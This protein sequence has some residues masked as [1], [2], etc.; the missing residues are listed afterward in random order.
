MNEA[1]NVT[2]TN[3][4]AGGFQY[5]N[6]V[7]QFFPHAEGYVKYE[8]N[9]YSYVFNYTDH[10]GNVRVSYSDI[11]KNGSLGNELQYYCKPRVPSNCIEYFTSSILEENH[12]YPFGLKHE[13]H[14]SSNAYQYKFN[15]IE[16]QDELGLNMSM[17]MRQYDPAI[18]RWVVQDPVVHFDYSPYNTLDNNPIY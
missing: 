7:L 13:T 9:N 10:L 15:G 5:K 1:T 11:D 2:Q 14:N 18:V 16:L 4:L 17:D 12:Y 6:N 3:Y 8:V